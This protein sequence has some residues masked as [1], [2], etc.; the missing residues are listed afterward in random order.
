MPLSSD[1][2]TRA[3]QLATL[4]A[5]IA[6]NVNT[7]P[8]GQPW[9]GSF[10][11]QAINTLP[12]NGDANAAIAG[13]YGLFP[14]VDFW[15]W[16]TSQSRM[17]NRRA[18][19]NTAGAGNQLDGLTAGKRESLIFGLDDTIDCRLAAVRTTIDDWCGGQAV[20]KAAIIDSFKRKL[21]NI[22]KLFATGG[23]GGLF[24]TPADLVV[25]GTISGSEVLE[26]RNLP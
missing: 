23:V 20:L 21:R 9:S 18:V 2:A 1:P 26:A 8:A 3:A 19:M 4:K 12:N 13:W 24:A 10:V 14:A 22:E 16:K 15:G 7:I 11:G 17:E 6:A 5:D 25:E